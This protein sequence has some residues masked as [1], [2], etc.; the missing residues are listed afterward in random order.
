LVAISQ[1]QLNGYGQ[2]ENKAE[3][4]AEKVVFILDLQGFSNLVSAEM[5]FAFPNTV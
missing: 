5:I 3:N 2:P 1:P 4:Y